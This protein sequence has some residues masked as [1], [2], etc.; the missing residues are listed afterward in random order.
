[1]K[2][3][4]SPACPQALGISGYQNGVCLYGSE[5]SVFDT[6]LGESILEPED[7]GVL[8][9]RR[10]ALPLWANAIAQSLGPTNPLPE[11]EACS[12]EEF[13]LPRST[14]KNARI[15]IPEF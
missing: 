4:I 5:H 6:P 2:K 11:S 12:K 9:T 10:T 14:F 13:V 8:H 7:S 1:M 3:S 15:P